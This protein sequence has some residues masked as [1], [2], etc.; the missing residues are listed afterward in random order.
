[1]PQTGCPQPL[2][3]LDDHSDAQLQRWLRTPADSLP[4]CTLLDGTLLADA[5]A[6]EMCESLARFHA[7]VA[8]RLYGDALANGGDAKRRRT[9]HTVVPSLRP[10]T[11]SS[12]SFPHLSTGCDVLD[13]ALRGGF[14]CGCVTEI[15]GM[16]S[17]GKTQLA[18]QLLLSAQLPPHLGGLGG[19]SVHISTEGRLPQQR[20]QQIAMERP[21]FRE[22]YQ[23]T[24]PCAHL[25]VHQAQDSDQ[26]GRILRQ[27]PTLVQN[28]CAQQGTR[29]VRPIRLVVID[30]I[31][32]PY[33][34]EDCSTASR[35]TVE[36]LAHAAR[37]KRIAE[38]G[39]GGIAI[40]VINQV[41]AVVSA[42]NDTC[43]RSASSTGM[44]PAS[45]DGSGAR[46]LTLCN[47]SP[48]WPQPSAS[49]HCWAESSVGRGGGA[50]G[51]IV[52]SLG[53]SWW[54]CANA[55]V[56]LS[57][58]NRGHLEAI[59]S[60]PKPVVK[61]PTKDVSSCPQQQQPQQQQHP[62]ALLSGPAGHDR[63]FLTVLSA[64][65]CDTGTQHAFS[66]TRCGVC[67]LG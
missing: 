8:V 24:D 21:L 51:G 33:R 53:L 32:A 35:R 29:E 5:H 37:L 9:S 34:S 46:T 50:G 56:L 4:H 26:L 3:W 27:L 58:T 54:S 49:T 2:S 16:A 65:A 41:T 7:A 42:T 61:A 62:A 45:G 36:L 14:P 57:R 1:M 63:R 48:P 31:A 40:V 18:L 13:R 22:H 25:L 20:L 47:G 17:C 19:A 64:P 38:T 11:A 28:R 23:S 66:V 39:V 67:G 44:H 55:R 43:I 30:S 6:K 10:H 52:P 60:V 59:V 15:T 12:R